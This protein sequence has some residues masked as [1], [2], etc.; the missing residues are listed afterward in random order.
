MR[1]NS[2]IHL[3]ERLL[4]PMK[5]VDQEFVFHP[6]HDPIV[7]IAPGW[8]AVSHR[9]LYDDARS[10]RRYYGQW[11]KKSSGNRFVYRCLRLSP[12]LKE[13]PDAQI[14]IDW[15]AWCRLAGGDSKKP[16][17][18]S[19]RK[20]CIFEPMLFGGHPDPMQRAAYQ[21]AFISLLISILGLIY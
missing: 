14:A 16:A 12:N 19:I 21:I 3:K 10:S 4:V 9:F 11:H 1:G 15:D 17:K 8:F 5:I 7:G 18:L 20:A 6:G 2:H 13:K